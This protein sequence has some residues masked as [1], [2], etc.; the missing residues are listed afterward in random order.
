[1][2]SV[3][4]G[5]DSEIEDRSSSAAG[6]M[7]DASSENAGSVLSAAGSVSTD[8]GIAFSLDNILAFRKRSTDLDI[9]LR[10]LGVMK[11]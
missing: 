2:S 11:G 10:M 5:V 6:S 3:Q 8:S 9:G 1:M 4:V 7:R